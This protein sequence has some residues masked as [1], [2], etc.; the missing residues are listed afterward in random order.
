MHRT[1]IFVERFGNVIK[2]ASHRNIC[3]RIRKSNQKVHRTDIFVKGFG[4]V[5]KGAPE[6]Q[7]IEINRNL[8]IP[9]VLNG[10]G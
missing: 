4:N 1:E 8:K 5:I 9:M 3:R 10:V 6:Y 2:G 7:F